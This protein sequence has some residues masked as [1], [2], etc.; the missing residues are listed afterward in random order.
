MNR[1]R[2]AATTLTGLLAS[3]FGAH[4]AQADKFDPTSTIKNWKSYPTK[5]TVTLYAGAEV[6]KQIEDN[7]KLIRRALV[8][9]NVQVPELDAIDA[10]FRHSIRQRL[11]QP[12][13]NAVERLLKS[14]FIT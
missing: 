8:Q 3:L 11:S 5:H 1:R 4:K 7:A 6:E 2:F 9:I 10:A 12:S 13:A 14:Q